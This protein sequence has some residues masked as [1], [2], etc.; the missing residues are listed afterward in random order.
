MGDDKPLSGR[1]A[2]VTGGGRGIG[3]HVAARLAKLGADVTVVGRTQATLDAQATAITARHKVRAAAEVV[4]VGDPEAIKNGF[5]RAADRLGPPTILVNNAGIALSAPFHRT[6]LDLW[7]RIMQVDA[8]GP[9]LCTQQVLKGM[10]AAGWGRIVTVASG[11][12]L[13][14]YPYVTAYCAAKHASVGMVRALAREVATKG[15]TV[16]A[17]CPGY[18]DTDIV[19]NTLDNIIAKTG[20]SREEAL[21]ELVAHNPQGRLVTCD[22]VADAVA[23]LCLPSSASITGQSIIIAGGE[24]M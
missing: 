9:F 5:A 22:E 4:D 8:T 23:W 7:N 2:V 6:D 18:V 15:V 16:N 10:L 20:R 14:G 11:A 19:T 12:G 1:H 24:L 13:S 17:V 21:A 3:A